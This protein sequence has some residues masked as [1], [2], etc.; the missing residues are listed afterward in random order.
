VIN[1]VIMLLFI[2]LRIKNKE[3]LPVIVVRNIALVKN[4]IWTP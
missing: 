3:F 2:L 1:V 4:F